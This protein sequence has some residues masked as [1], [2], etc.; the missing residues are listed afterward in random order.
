MLA[1][2]TGMAYLLHW[3]MMQVCHTYYTVLWHRYGVIIML[4]YNTGMVY[5]SGWLIALVWHTYYTGL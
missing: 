3:L 2:S 5:L 4:A 1:Y